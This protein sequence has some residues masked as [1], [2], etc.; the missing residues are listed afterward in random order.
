MNAKDFAMMKKWAEGGHLGGAH[1]I[2]VQAAVVAARMRGREDIA[3]LCIAE[4]R[5]RDSE[6]AK[7]REKFPNMTWQG[8]SL[9][10]EQE[11]KDREKKLRK[12]RG[13]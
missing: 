5:H 6:R 13:R 8:R 7:L 1:T 2:D 11:L 10:S 3:Q 9:P 12:R 4:L